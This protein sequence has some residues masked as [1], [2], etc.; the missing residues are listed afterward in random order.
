VSIEGLLPVES[1]HLVHS[2]RQIRQR[3]WTKLN[4][5]TRDFWLVGGKVQVVTT[6]AH[7]QNLQL[8]LRRLNKSLHR[9]H[10]TTSSDISLGCNTRGLLLLELIATTQTNYEML[11]G[12]IS[13]VCTAR[14]LRNETQYLKL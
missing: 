2:Q 12:K 6:L 9:Y 4:C 3:H 8:N 11:T 1:V 13:S 10:S 14:N 7:S 5:W